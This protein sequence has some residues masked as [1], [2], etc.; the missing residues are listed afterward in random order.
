MS[1]ERSWFRIKCDLIKILELSCVICHWMSLHQSLPGTKWPLDPD[2]QWQL[3]L[4]MI[5]VWVQA[6]SIKVICKNPMNSRDLQRMGYYSGEWPHSLENIAFSKVL[7]RIPWFSGDLW[8]IS[9]FSGEYEILWRM[10]EI[11]VMWYERLFNT[12]NAINLVAFG[13]H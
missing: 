2:H 3:G 7:W 1:I 5:K 8:R 9:L 13:G 12:F 6:T 10:L 11:W 4:I